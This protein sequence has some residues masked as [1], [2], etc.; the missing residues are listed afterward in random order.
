MQP[1][2]SAGNM[3]NIA[4]ALQKLLIKKHKPKKRSQR[5]LLVHVQHALSALPGSRRPSSPIDGLFCSTEMFFPA[6]AQPPAEQGL[7]ESQERGGR[8]PAFVERGTPLPLLV[9]FLPVGQLFL[10][11]LI[12]EDLGEVSL[13]RDHTHFN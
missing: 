7:R 11:T 10:L 2:G 3:Q 8:K 1:A 9:I 6:A 5:G 12:N 13:L 4:L